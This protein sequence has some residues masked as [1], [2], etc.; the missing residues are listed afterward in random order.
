M[1][2]TPQTLLVPFALESSRVELT[3]QL[4]MPCFCRSAVESYKLPEDKYEFANEIAIYPSLSGNNWSI[5]K[6]NLE[7][8]YTF[9]S[10]FPMVLKN[11]DIVPR[12]LL[13]MPPP[14][15]ITEGELLFHELRRIITKKQ[16]NPKFVFISYVIYF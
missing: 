3:D 14:L 13:K 9:H 4:M 5:F 11:E 10:W 16:S 6:Y 8:Y 2:C 15:S 7:G 1:I 12:S